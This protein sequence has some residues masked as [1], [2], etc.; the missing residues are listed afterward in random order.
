MSELSTINLSS[1]DLKKEQE[2]QRKRGKL[3]FKT[4]KKGKIKVKLGMYD[5]DGTVPD[6]IFQY[7]IHNAHFRPIVDYTN[8]EVICVMDCY[9]DDIDIFNE[10]GSEITEKLPLWLVSEIEYKIENKFGSFNIELRYM[11]QSDGKGKKSLVN[12]SKEED[13][14]LINKTRVIY[15]GLKKG[16]KIGLSPVDSPYHEVHWTLPNK[17]YI[18]IKHRNQEETERTGVNAY[19]ILLLNTE[20]INYTKTNDKPLRNGEKHLISG[21]IT[22]QFK[23]HGITVYWGG[24]VPKYSIFSPNSVSPDETYTEVDVTPKSK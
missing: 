8:G 14:K 11:Q 3:I 12:E 13:Q 17:F 16:G 9:Y 21:K 20:T 1:E 5:Q 2:R 4:F 7:Q 10:D 18:K 19:P 15:K 24:Q 6:M 22:D 23:K